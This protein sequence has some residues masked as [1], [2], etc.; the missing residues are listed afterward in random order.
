MSLF[1]KNPPLSEAVKYN[2]T[3][4]KTLA[5]STGNGRFPSFE[6]RHDVSL[7]KWHFSV[8]LEPERYWFLSV[9]VREDGELDKFAL[10]YEAA[11]DSH[12]EFD[13]ETAIRK[14]L[15]QAGD[16]NLLLHDL[17]IRFIRDHDGLA[18]LELL[19]PYITA[20]FHFD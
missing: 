4:I 19:Q 6:L 12:Y 9:F 3:N 16:E 5:D 2:L 10:D 20:E 14:L 8:S 15:Y 7:K 13:D 18:L 17:F 1:Q 11:L